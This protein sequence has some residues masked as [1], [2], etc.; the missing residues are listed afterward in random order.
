MSSPTKLYAEAPTSGVTA[1][2]D[3]AF[4]DIIKVACACVRACSVMSNSLQ[5]HG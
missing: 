3:G 4:M 1:F 2:G 5:L